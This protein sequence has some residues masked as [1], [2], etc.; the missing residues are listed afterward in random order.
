MFIKL[1]HPY[2]NTI[3]I[4][5]Q[6]FNYKNRFRLKHELQLQTELVDTLIAEI[7]EN[8]DPYIIQNAPYEAFIQLNYQY[9]QQQTHSIH[10]Q[11]SKYSSVYV[12]AQFTNIGIINDLYNPIHY[13]Q[14][15]NWKQYSL[16]F[17]YEYKNFV[18]EYNFKS[19]YTEPKIRFMYKM[20][21]PWAYFKHMAS[22]KLSEKEL[23]PKE[24]IEVYTQ[25]AAVSN[26]S[27]GI[28]IEHLN[29]F[30][31]K[32]IDA[33]DQALVEAETLARNETFEQRG[34]EQIQLQPMISSM[35]IADELFVSQSGNDTTV[36]MM[37]IPFL[38]GV[39][40]GIS[41]TKPLEQ[42]YRWCKKRI[43]KK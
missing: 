12:K 35:R 18:I 16:H 36:G 31:W 26:Q 41:L 4:Q 42:L 28:E 10:Y 32:P 15:S 38:I 37:V 40:V 17:G 5:C 33:A 30:E 23:E 9:D 20:E 19:N 8:E 13:I 11:I 3:G 7:I 34:S 24:N 25:D 21:F 2:S 29:Q 27:D 1:I 14:A 39:G 6:S 43:D 22:M